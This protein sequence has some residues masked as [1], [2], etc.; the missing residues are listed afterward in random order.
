M[1]QPYTSERQFSSSVTIGSRHYL[2]PA[3]NSPSFRLSDPDPND[4]FVVNFVSLQVF[5]NILPLKDLS[6]ADVPG[7]G[8]QP[9]DY[10]KLQEAKRYFQENKA[11]ILEKYRGNFIAILDNSVVDHDKEFSELAKRVYDKFGYQMIYMPFVESEPSVLRIPSP[12]VGKQRV[13]ALR[14]EV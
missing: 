10:V 7:E 8:A 5:K 11:Q 1:N 6:V 4:K 2:N 13:D 14:K 3:L 9:A 12:R